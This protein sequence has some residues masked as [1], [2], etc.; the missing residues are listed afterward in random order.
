MSG[1]GT[2]PVRTVRGNISIARTVG[3]TAPQ[4]VRERSYRL[5][6]LSEQQG[7]SLGVM[8]E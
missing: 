3:F 1:Y 7:I 2:G 8:G 6:P 4:S 5:H